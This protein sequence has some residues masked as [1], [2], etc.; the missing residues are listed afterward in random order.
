MSNH[1]D[2]PFEPVKDTGG[3]LHRLEQNLEQRYKRTAD[4]KRPVLVPV[5]PRIKHLQQELRHHPD[6]KAKYAALGGDLIG[7]I[8]GIAA[9]LGVI[10]DG[11]YTQEEVLNLCD[12]LVRRLRDKRG[13]L[14]V[15]G[16]NNV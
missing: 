2:R 10:L 13:A 6:M 15:I 1:S 5:D 3:I 7:I 14:V 16:A 12:L 11:V 4:H 8:Q 9:D